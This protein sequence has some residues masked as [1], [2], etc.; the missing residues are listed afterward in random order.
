MDV[1]VIGIYA[2][3]RTCISVLRV[4][5]GIADRPV[6]GETYRIVRVVV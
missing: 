3:D 2:D 4:N 6:R 1:D 5:F